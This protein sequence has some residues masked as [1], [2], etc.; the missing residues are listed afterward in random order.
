MTSRARG[1]YFPSLISLLLVKIVLMFCFVHSLLV[2][3]C[4]KCGTVVIGAST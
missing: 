2:M 1:D 4:Q 3:V